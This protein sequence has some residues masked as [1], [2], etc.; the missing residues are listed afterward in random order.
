MLKQCY[1]KQTH[2]L[3][4][5]ILDWNPRGR[6]QLYERK[7]RVR[8]LVKSI[9]CLWYDFEHKCQK[10]SVVCS[11]QSVIM[12]WDWLWLGQQFSC[13][14]IGV[15]KIVLLIVTLF[16]INRASRADIYRK[17]LKLSHQIRH[18]DG[19]LCCYVFSS[20]CNN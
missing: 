17:L 5:E 8:H 3:F 18:N 7:Y 6:S 11:G 2:S 1:M 13:F 16:K 15:K 12:N 9:K 14:S 19:A 4:L 20:I 10:Q